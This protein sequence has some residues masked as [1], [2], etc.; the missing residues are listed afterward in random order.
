VTEPVTEPVDPPGPAA[1]AAA[2]RP[3]LITVLREWG[4]IGCTGFGG[5]PTHIKMLRDLCVDRRGWLDAA[6]FEDAV[7][8]CNLLP[9]PA[10]TELA[11]FCAWR[12]RGRPGALIGGA[13]FILPGLIVILALAALFLE[14]TP[15]VWVLGA[16]AGAGA[17]VAAVAVQ[18]A[19]SLTPASWG[20]AREHGSAWRWL[21]YLAAGAAAAAT[22]G[23]WLVLVLLGSVTGCVSRELGPQPLAVPAAVAEG[24]GIRAAL[25]RGRALGQADLVHAIGGI[26]ALALVYGVSRSMLLILL[27][28]QGNQAQAVALVLADLVLSP[29]LFIGAALLYLDQVARVK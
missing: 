14:G 4:R 11:I 23:P 24:L 27:H 28:T 20:R 12:V 16:G 5:P 1:V 2:S 25:R 18:A 8:A 9:G 21:A 26:A 6:E 22:I 10:S 17:A 29:L 13:A 7:A 19:W 15:P 3:S